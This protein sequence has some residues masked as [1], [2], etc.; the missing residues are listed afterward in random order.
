MAN[1]CT[2]SVKSGVIDC[3][4]KRAATVFSNDELLGKLLDRIGEA[5]NQNNYPKPF[6]G[7]AIEKGIRQ[8]RMPRLVEQEFDQ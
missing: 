1:A 8:R 7:K 6:V 4:D 2:E 5:M 3:F